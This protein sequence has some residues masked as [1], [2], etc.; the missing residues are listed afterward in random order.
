[1]QSRDSRTLDLVSV[2][3]FI[4]AAL[5]AILSS[6]ATV[7]S[8][9]EFDTATL[10]G[11][12]YD[13][14]HNP[15]QWASVSIAGR[16]PVYTDIDGRFAV[17]KVARGVVAIEVGADGF[18][19]HTGEFLFA[20]R[21]QVLYLRLHSGRSFVRQAIGALDSGD[22]ET[23]VH[24]AGKALMVLPGDPEVRFIAALASYRAGHLAM[25]QTHLSSFPEACGYEA[26][27]LLRADLV[28]GVATD[29]E[30]E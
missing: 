16:E 2:L 11:M 8:P 27:R 4:G 23:A 28:A 24:L 10:H 20:N 22:G 1:M 14:E 5:V 6:C 12:V 17:P 29:L 7:P 15:V 13:D 21:T 19:P 9:V 30:V 26:V 3:I 18:A 25:A